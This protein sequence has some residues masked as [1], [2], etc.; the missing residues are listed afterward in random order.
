M[1]EAARPRCNLLRAGFSEKSPIN[2]PGARPTYEGFPPGARIKGM[3]PINLF[4]PARFALAA[5][6]ALPFIVSPAEEKATPPARAIHTDPYA[7]TIDFPGGPLS[8]LVA[9]LASKEGPTLTII[10]SEGLDPMLPAFSVRDVRIDSVIGAL[11]RVL[12]P[13]GLGLSPTG[14]NLAVLTKFTHIQAP[15]FASLQ[16][17]SKLGDQSIEEFIGAIQAACLFAHP[18]QKASTLRFKYHPGTRLLFVAGTRQEVEVAYQVFG[19]LPDVPSKNP[20]PAAEK[21]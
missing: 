10:Q 6:L 3:H 7:I 21:K 14:P 1:I 17:G 8:K 16:I 20:S 13:Q 5:L 12:E 19:S 18:D 15:A 9:M 11:G 4:R 2:R